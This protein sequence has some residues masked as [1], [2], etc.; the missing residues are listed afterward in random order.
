MTAFYP[1]EYL[2]VLKRRKT[3]FFSVFG[4]IF[5]AAF[6]FAL[7]WSRYE[8][9]A[10]V[11]VA[12]PEISMDAVETQDDR[13]QSA[14]AMADLEIS[15]LKQKVL[16]TSSLAEIIAK[17]D[18]YPGA[19]KN[20]PI[21]YIAEGM[22]KKIDIRLVSTSLANPASAQKAS[23]LQLSAIAF[24]LS[25]EYSN[26]LLAQK[27]VNE[28]V[29]RFLDEDLKE[30]RETAQKTTEFLEGQIDILS[31]ALE[32][33]EQKIAEFRVKNGN[34]RPDA[35]AFNQQA[36]IT[37]T[38]RL[39]SIESD[40]ISNLGRIGAL[41]SQLAQTEPYSR[42]V[43]DDGAVLTTPA[44]QLRALK[45]QYA[46]LTAKYGP[47]HPDVIKISRQ[48]SAM[49]KD[50]RPSGRGAGVSA[51]LKAKIEDV[52]AKLD[53]AKK[54]YGEEHP[55]Y[56][57]L[58]KQLESLQAQV[59]NAGS[60]GGGLSVKTDADNPAYLQIVAQLDSAQTQQEALEKQRDEIKAQQDDYQK[61]IAA[62]P[63]VEQKMAALARDY[64]NM[65][66]MYRELKAKK[67][68][69]DMNQTIEEGHVGRRLAV[70]DPP[71]LPLK[72]QP[73][74]SLILGVGFFL[75]VFAGLGSVLVLQILSQ[76]IVGPH[77]LE[78]LTGVAPLVT[79]PRLRTLDE[80]VEIRKFIF[81]VLL[82]A[83][84]VIVV[85]SLIWLLTLMPFDVL[86]A[87]MGRK[88]GLS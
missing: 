68:A 47:D 54:T 79:I 50:V 77:H 85:L 71:E 30:R 36:S 69:A 74:R 70:I 19:R 20:T 72:T 48:I 6:I 3:V 1:L 80:R 13:V 86:V 76:S 43:S 61:A 2:S 9:S 27:T 49:E 29:S 11:E 60:S 83:P 10:M 4:V 73:S 7:K 26:P 75:A 57:S 53:V 56:L 59:K 23:A 32:E 58:K 41:R 39:L 34:I 28:L 21:A 31:Q 88:I 45:S 15:R 65:M 52:K 82:V 40:I 63:E 66:V 8:A 17:L 16:S 62:N 18:L 38:S 14:E 33:Q 25:F 37:T 24:V 22:R 64:D 84:V 51:R 46:E 81:G 35:L 78:S 42:V 12:R 55:D 5:L 67:L 44:I 87:A